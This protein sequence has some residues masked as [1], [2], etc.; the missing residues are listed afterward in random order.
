MVKS[1]EH[2]QA[3]VA[4]IHM[5]PVAAGMV[6]DPGNWEWSDYL[7]WIGERASVMFNPGLRD[8]WYQKPDSYRRQVL[9]MSYAQ[10]N[11]ELMLDDKQV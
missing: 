10:L 6:S 2:M 1:Y 3:L 5:N 11:T 7:C 4:Y 9:E 8:S